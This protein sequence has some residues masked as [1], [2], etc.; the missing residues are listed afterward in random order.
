MVFGAGKFGSSF[1]FPVSNVVSSFGFQNSIF[2][3]VKAIVG[4]VQ[5]GQ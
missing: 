2:V 1:N 5:T 4:I 3:G